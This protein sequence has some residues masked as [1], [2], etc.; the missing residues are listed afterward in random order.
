MTISEALSEA[1][2]RLLRAS[3]AIPALEESPRADADLL[4]GY[5]L[6]CTHARLLAH[7]SEMVEPERYEAFTAL[8]ERRATGVPVAYLLGDAGFYGRLFRVDERVL[9]PRPETELIIEAVL[10][11]LRLR[12]GREL[13]VADIGTGS[14][15]IAVTLACELP[16]LRVWGTDCSA[17]ALEVARENALRHGAQERCVFVAGDLAV[18]LAGLA[19]FDCVVA[20]LPYIPTAEVP[21][22][23]NPVGYEPNVAFDGGDDGLVLYR[24]LLWDLPSM[25]ASGASC[26]FEA[27][28][29]TIDTLAA[30]CERAF[31]GAYIEI[32]EDYAS[33]ERYVTVSVEASS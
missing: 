16:T 22:A 6:G 29:P 4:L 17:D 8:V 25:L 15:A 13:R 26:F 12:R 2:A 21:A 23:P 7:G 20:N 3:R 9:I 27:A 30:L 28:P 11:D 18:P 19:P 32:G 1:R 5:V 24:R 10:S 33:L 14:G 31:P